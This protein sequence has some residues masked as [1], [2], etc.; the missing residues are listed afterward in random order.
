MRQ[1]LLTN[2]LETLTMADWLERTHN[3]LWRS[4]QAALMA[5]AAT[6]ILTGGLLGL[7]K[8]DDRWVNRLAIYGALLGAGTGTV[9][10]L[11][12]DN[13]PLPS[14]ELHHCYPSP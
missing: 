7:T 14:Q 13:K 4:T 9:Y 6:A 10:G 1:H 11:V 3:P 2:F 12:G 5:A 8:I